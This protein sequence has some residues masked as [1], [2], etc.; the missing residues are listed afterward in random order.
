MAFIAHSGLVVGDLDRS[1]RFYCELLGFTFDRDLAMTSAQVSDFLGFEP[2]GADLK[3]IYLNLG[4]FQLELM[5]FSPSGTNRVRARK[6]N[7]TGLTHLSVAVKD[8]QAIISKVADYG[9]EFVTR[10]ADTA[11]MLRDPDGQLIEIVAETWALD[12]RRRGQGHLRRTQK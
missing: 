1:V 2:P 12:E 4:E 5:C 8:V 11:A 7:E 6:M 9:G 10:I 3:A